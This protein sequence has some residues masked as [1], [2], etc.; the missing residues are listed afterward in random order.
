MNINVKY[1]DSPEGQDA[2]GKMLVTNKYALAAGLGWST[3]DVLMVSHPKGYMPTLSRYVYFT[4][5]AMGM[6][7]AFTLGTY[8]ATKLRGK[9]DK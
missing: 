6:A 1:Y 8:F 3:I 9:D 7:S 4:V 2:F 5:P